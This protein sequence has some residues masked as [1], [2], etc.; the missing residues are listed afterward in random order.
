MKSIL[1][2]LLLAVSL[3]AFCGTVSAQN[4]RQHLTREQLAESQARHIAKEMAM[5]SATVK[6]FTDTFCQFQREIWALGS[7]P[8]Q[9]GR[10]MTD[11]E[12]EQALKE[13][14]AHRQKILDLPIQMLY[15]WRILPI[16]TSRPVK[17][18]LLMEVGCF[19]LMWERVVWAFRLTV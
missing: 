5:D 17:V 6:R 13:R 12:T 16:K 10:Q 4:K 2:L 7:R 15:C 11:K 9:S 14:F 3:T 8:K 1:K 19:G 18:R